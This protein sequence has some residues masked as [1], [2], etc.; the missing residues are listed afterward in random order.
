MK[1][2]LVPVSKAL[3]KVPFDCGYPVLNEY[4]RLYALK[5]DRLSIGKTFVAVDEDEGV[6]G[7]MTLASAQV[8]ARSLPEAMRA[9]LPRYP[10]PAFRI[11]KLAIDTRFQGAGA[12]SWL[13]RQA[14]EKALSVSAEVGL[15]AV[16]VDTID[17]K[18]K[19]FYR[20]YGFEAFSE[21]PLTL[22]LP[23]ATIARALSG[24]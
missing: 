5:N 19:G 9:K 7:Y 8:E 16:I 18:A 13:L 12:G 20:K 24:E 23:L 11:A 1:F 15:Y 10:V 14:L 2:S 6:V 17:E 22:F 3:Q 4:F 21:Y